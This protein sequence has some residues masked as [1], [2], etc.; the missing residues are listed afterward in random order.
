MFFSSFFSRLRD[1][2]FPFSFCDDAEQSTAVDAV[3]GEGGFYWV[4]RLVCVTGNEKMNDD[5]HFP[6]NELLRSGD[7]SE[8]CIVQLHQTDITLRH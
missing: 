6:E 4:R 8:R 7:A 3:I 2:H 5:E 1:Y